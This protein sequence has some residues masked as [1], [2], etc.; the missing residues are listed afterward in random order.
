RENVEL[1]TEI[2]RNPMDPGEALRLVGLD[3][4]ADHFPAQMSGGEQQRVAIARALAKQ[5]DVL[6]C[7][8]P[9]GALDSTTGRAVLNV[10]KTVN[11]RL[12][13][14][15]MIVTHAAAQAAMA[16]RVIHFADGGVREVVENTTKLDPDQIEW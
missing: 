9:T 12:G 5:P 3:K 14:T 13:T 2:A 15:I 1:V 16:D 10:L 4:R 8:E 11:E 6:F 7:D